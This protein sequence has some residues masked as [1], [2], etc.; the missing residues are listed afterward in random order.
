MIQLGGLLLAILLVMAA[1][2]GLK[3]CSDRSAERLSPAAARALEDQIVV[4]PDATMVAPKGTVGRSIVDWMKAPPSGQA[5]FELG[6]HQFQPDSVEP[7]P[8]SRVRIDR[9]ATMMRDYPTIRARIIGFSSASDDAARNRAFSEQRAAWVAKLITDQGVSPSRLS[10]EGRGA[11][12]HPVA[13]A[14]RVDPE[15]V[16]IQLVRDR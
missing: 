14:G 4:L 8:E 3:A 12:P 16:A 1:G 2:L 10:W 7:T 6:G 11:D 5:Y 9:F 13:V 15:R